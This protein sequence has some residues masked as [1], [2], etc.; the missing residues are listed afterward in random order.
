MRSKNLKPWALSQGEKATLSTTGFI[1]SITRAK[2]WLESQTIAL[3]SPRGP[4]GCIVAMH[5]S[6]VPRESRL[7]MEW[8]GLCRPEP[9]GWRFKM[10]F[11]KAHSLE[12]RYKKIKHSKKQKAPVSVQSP[13]LQSSTRQDS[14]H[15]SFQG[16]ADMQAR[17]A[18]LETELQGAS[19]A[20]LMAR[21]A[22]MEAKLYGAPKR[23]R[24]KARGRKK[25]GPHAWTPCQGGLPSLGKHA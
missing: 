15:A 21:I 1:G 25:G 16:D 3:C 6:C 17:I 19:N 8:S 4:S 12:T 9:F 20:D 13:T 2:Y 18:E 22:K 24:R 7:Q 11:L 10:S 5:H 23:A 14:V